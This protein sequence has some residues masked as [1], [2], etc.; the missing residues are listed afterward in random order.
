[1]LTIRYIFAIWVSSWK[2]N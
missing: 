1:M 2:V